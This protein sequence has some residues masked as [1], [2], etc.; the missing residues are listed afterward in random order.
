MRRLRWL[1][2]YTR[3]SSRTMR[4]KPIDAFPR[5]GLETRGKVDVVVDGVSG[6][7]VE[8]IS[9]T[10]VGT[11]VDAVVS[12]VVVSEPSAYTSDVGTRAHETTTVRAMRMGVFIVRKM[13]TVNRY[14]ERAK[15][16]SAAISRA[17]AS[18]FHDRTAHLMRTGNF[19]TPCRASRSP[20]GAEVSGSSPPSSIDIMCL[21]R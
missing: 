8:T 4:V 6:T 1:Y 16:Y 5:C 2:T 12:G 11:V 17:S 18:V 14:A 21:K 13:I 9:G 19:T 20:S 15:R 10:V 3:C 7:V